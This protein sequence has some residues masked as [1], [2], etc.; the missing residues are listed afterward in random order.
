MKKQIMSVA[1]LILAVT[2]C[3]CNTAGSSSGD[4]EPVGQTTYYLTSY[5][6]FE[7][8]FDKEQSVDLREQIE[9]E[10]SEYGQQ[11]E[12]FMD[13]MLAKGDVMTPFIDGE[14][15]QLMDMQ[16]EYLKV[17]I[18]TSERYGLPWFFFNCSYSGQHVIVK[19]TSPQEIGIQGLSQDMDA[20]EVVYCIDPDALNVHNH[21][22]LKF[23]GVKVYE[24]ELQLKNGTVTAMI[25]EY[26]DHEW[27]WV[28]FY[29][30]EALVA[31]RADASLLSDE[32]WAS[33]DID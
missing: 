24:Q 18:M 13:G 10:K 19:M 27:L 1:I 5:E 16:E 28:T 14:K 33:F 23:R 30:K 20:S 7:Q 6:E 21:R 22:K 15:M 29:Y 12:A 26:T 4:C 9:R 2:L 25:Q 8:V 11:Y 17:A 32:F 3:A 31:V